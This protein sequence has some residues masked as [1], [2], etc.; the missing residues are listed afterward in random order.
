MEI[1][2]FFAICH[3]RHFKNGLVEV[4]YVQISID[5]IIISHKDPARIYEMWVLSH[6][7]LY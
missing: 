3:G 4:Y 5:K 2:I 6:V 1:S 7:W